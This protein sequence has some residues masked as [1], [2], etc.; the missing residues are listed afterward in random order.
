MDFLPHLAGLDLALVWPAAAIVRGAKAR[1]INVT[2]VDNFN[3]VTGKGVLGTVDGKRL[4]LGNHA[5]M[6]QKSVDI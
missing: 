4:E 5:L 2:T 6:E 3:S 1:K